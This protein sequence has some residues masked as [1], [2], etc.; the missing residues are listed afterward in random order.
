M[1]F[2]CTG[3]E[4]QFPITRVDPRCDNCGEPLELPLVTGAINKHVPWHSCLTERYRDFF[5]FVKADTSL[6]LGEGFTP[7]IS[8][9]NLS[10]ELGLAALYLKNETLNPTWSFKDRGTLMGVQ[11]ALNLGYKR[12]G[13]V[14][15]GNMA[16]SVAAY[17]AH[18]GLETFIFVSDGI[19]AEKLGP[20]SIYGP[21]LVKV[22]GDYGRLYYE[23]LKVGSE[24]GIY[25][26]N[27][28]VP[29]RVE[30]SKTIAYEICEQ[31]DFCVPDFV[32]VPVSAGGN[33]R[34]IIKGFRE[35]LASG[36]ID[37]LPV[38][39][40]AQAAGC[41]PVYRAY[42]HGDSTIERV[43]QPH[44]VAHAIENP[45]P[46]SGNEVL[47]QLR[48]LNGLS[49]AVEEQ[50]I[51]Y[52]QRRLA[53]AGIFAQPASAVPL[54]ALKQLRDQGI[55]NE[56]HTAV[57]VVTGSGLKYTAVL[58]QHGLTAYSCSLRELG[59][60]IKHTFLVIQ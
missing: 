24:N 56:D 10:G 52:W 43:E 34:G 5:P 54:A 18:A 22:E 53:Q 57:C 49:V 42:S 20:V 30:G 26:I 29:F 13:T 32:V 3:C 41:A 31:L 17:G 7:L 38:F 48:T 40:A 21:H 51:L 37:R 8:E 27:S 1:R 44:T 2:I 15:T 14:S 45:Y 50:D 39:V 28:D 47:R 60:F 46:P 19:A 16:A 59:S 25:F 11:H 33:I 55:V 35:F 6:S 23:S 58:Q 9:A 4:K 36:L 12:I